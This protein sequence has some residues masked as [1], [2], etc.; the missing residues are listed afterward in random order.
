M[1][2]G[3]APQVWSV[4]LAL[5]GIRADQTMLLLCPERSYLGARSPLASGVKSKPQARTHS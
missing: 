1:R 2:V 4:A 5:R 3:R